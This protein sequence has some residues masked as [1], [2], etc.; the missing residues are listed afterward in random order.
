MRVYVVNG[1][2]EWRTDFSF[3]YLYIRKSLFYYVKHIFAWL[4]KRVDKNLAI[5]FTFEYILIWFGK[6]DVKLRLRKRYAGSSRKVWTGLVF[7]NRRS[8]FAQENK[9]ENCKKNRR[10]VILYSLVKGNAIFLYLTNQ[11]CETEQSDTWRI[12][13]LL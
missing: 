13:V 11:Q 7:C 9:K 2:R 4:F 5:L 1:W 6:A 12:L 10:K 8:C 3:T